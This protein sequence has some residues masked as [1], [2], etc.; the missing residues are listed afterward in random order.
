MTV[1]VN[2]TDRQ[3]ALLRWTAGNGGLIHTGVWTAG[4]DR[5]ALAALVRYGLLSPGRRL[6]TQPARRAARRRLGSVRLHRRVVL[7]AAQGER[8]LM[9]YCNPCAE[10]RGWPTDT[11]MR[12][13]GRCEICGTGA[14]CN[15]VPS[16]MP[17]P[18]GV[19]SYMPDRSGDRYYVTTDHRGEREV[20]KDDYVNVERQA[21]FRNTHGRPD[22]PATGSFGDGWLSGRIAYA[23]DGPRSNG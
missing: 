9:F 10:P 13:R 15:D 18:A 17:P 20:G 23:A 12:S 1:R 4:P 2:L 6:D 5:K 8:C 14:V 16:G 21:G 22:E 3:A 19:P 11:L 7:D